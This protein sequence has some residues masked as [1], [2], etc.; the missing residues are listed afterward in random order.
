[1]QQGSEKETARVPPSL[2]SP[3]SAAPETFLLRDAVSAFP[4]AFG[5]LL[6]S[7]PGARCRVSA[8][9]SRSP[10]RSFWN[11]AHPL[12]GRANRPVLSLAT[13]SQFRLLSIRPR[14]SFSYP[15]DRLRET[16]TPAPPDQAACSK[17]PSLPRPRPP[18]ESP[19][20]ARPPQSSRTAPAPASPAPQRSSADPAPWRAPVRPGP[21]RSASQ[22]SISGRSLPSARR[23]PA[24]RRCTFRPPLRAAIPAPLPTSPACAPHQNSLVTRC[25][26][27]LN[28]QIF[29]GLVVFVRVRRILQIIQDPRMVH[30]LEIIE[31]SEHV[32][33]TFHLRR[34]A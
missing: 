2:D 26:P 24:W 20:R 17:L 3:L 18:A 5:P 28:S 13:D 7:L 9:L 23:L 21:D 27:F 30:D 4:I 22:R 11:R 16:K 19:T 34:L 10:W 32:H 25:P 15:A 8:A 6:Q 31:V 1:M 14:R 33:L 12:R 29:Q